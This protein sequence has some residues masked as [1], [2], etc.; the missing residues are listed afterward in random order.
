M[1][2]G[3]R[4]YGPIIV[5]RNSIPVEVR[6]ST[7]EKLIDIT[8]FIGSSVPV[9]LETARL[10][11]G[12]QFTAIQTLLDAGVFER[13]M[14]DKPNSRTYVLLDPSTCVR[15]LYEAWLDRQPMPKTHEE[16]D[17]HRSVRRISRIPHDEPLPGILLEGAFRRLIEHGNISKSEVVIFLPLHPENSDSTLSWMHWRLHGYRKKRSNFRRSGL[18]VE[19]LRGALPPNLQEA[20]FTCLTTDHPYEFE[21]PSP[22]MIA[23]L[24]QLDRLF[25]PASLYVLATAPLIRRSDL[26]L[27]RVRSMERIQEIFAHYAP[28]RDLT[29]AEVEASLRGYL[30]DDD[31]QSNDPPSVRLLTVTRWA[32]IT[33]ALQIY[34]SRLLPE[35]ASTMQAY[36]PTPFVITPNF[37]KEIKERLGDLRAEGRARRQQTALAALADLELILT[38]ATNRRDELRSFGEAYRHEVDQMLADEE[39]RIFSVRVPCLDARGNLSGGINKVRFK[40]WRTGAAWNSLLHTPRATKNTRQIA[41]KRADLNSDRYEEPFIVEHLG[42]EADDG[43]AATEPWMIGLDRLGVTQSLANG[44]PGLKE[45]RHQ[46]IYSLGLP[47]S[48]GCTKGLLTFEEERAALKRNGLKQDRHFFPLEEIEHALRLAYVVLD[49]VSQ[50]YNRAQEIRQMVR[51][52]WDVAES[53]DGEVRHSQ[54]ALPKIPK[55]KDL[56]TATPVKVIITETALN[57]IYDLCELHQRRCSY[58]KFPIMQAARDLRWKCPPGEY[59]ISYNSTPLSKYEGQLFLRYL[60]AGWPEYTFH[61]FRYV[62][63]KDA[64]LD[65][66]TPEE[67]ASMLG[68]ETLA[69]AEDYMCLEGFDRELKDYDS[70]RRRMMAQDERLGAPIVGGDFE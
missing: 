64:A 70:I 42:T 35:A 27:E 69:I 28:E 4:P 32:D 62:M 20:P 11:L 51:Q 16:F 58:A 48:R 1:T 39:S 68:Q 57:E 21:A 24:W 2:N 56:V 19:D 67:V 33:Q 29:P 6:G 25:V 43:H 60:L 52:G 30:F 22:S 17:V 53:Y 44:D 3:R 31:V 12:L 50:S 45:Q 23:R 65:G 18:T 5:S 14:P 66:H 49:C 36:A 38:A 59:V 55:G 54:R 13:Y 9:T 26:L 7:R 46:T 37:A 61:D 8:P 41:G 40:I 10:L 15:D 47:G 63:A 34:L